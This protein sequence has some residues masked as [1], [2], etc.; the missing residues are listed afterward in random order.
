MDARSKYQS[1]LIQYQAGVVRDLPA[2]S[3]FAQELARQPRS[4]I[5]SLEYL[6]RVFETDP[7]LT[8]KLTGAANSVFFAHEHFAVLTLPEALR[9]VGVRYAM[10]LVWEAPPLPAGIEP[11]EVSV[12]WAHCMTVAH[13][14]RSIAKDANSAPFEPDVAHLVAMIHD[15]GYLLQ[16]K[17]SPGT[18]KDIASRLEHDEPEADSDSHASQ[19]EELAKFWSLPA[20]AVAA[21]SAHHDPQRCTGERARWLS[22]VIATSEALLRRSLEPIQISTG[23]WPGEAFVEL[24]GVNR[25]HLPALRK[26]ALGIW[27]ECIALAF[28]TTPPRRMPHLQLIRTGPNDE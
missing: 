19:G 16:L 7:F 3:P 4:H 11:N 10:N 14:A 23:D 1:F 18:W 20:D 9:R 25:D 12:L 15:I 27:D 8:A 2:I 21:I 26:E 17:C 28:R 6:I 13:V 24:L 5:P 22:A